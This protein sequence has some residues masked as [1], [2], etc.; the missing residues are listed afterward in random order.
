[1]RKILCLAF[2]LTAI[3]A[4]APAIATDEEWLADNPQS[5][6][7]C[8]W[9]PIKESL[10]KTESCSGVQKG[11][12]TEGPMTKYGRARGKYQ[13][14][15]ETQNN[16]LK[17]YPECSGGHDCR[18]AN[19][20]NQ[21]CWP[22]QECL[23]DRLLAE[24]LDRARKDP[25]CQALI[26]Q[27]VSG[28][29][30]KKDC[31]GRYTCT[32][33]VTWSG[34]AAAMHLGGSDACANV[35]ANGVGDND[36]HTSESGYM[37]EHSGVAVPQDC[38]PP[39]YDPGTA[40]PTLTLPQ[41]EFLENTGDTGFINTGGTIKQNWVAGLMLMAEQFSVNME[42]QLEAIGML[43]DAKDQQEAQRDFQRK[44]AEAHRD[45]QPSEQ[46]CTFGSF[47]TNLASTHRRAD[48]TR[49]ALSQE[50][51]QRETAAGD[52]KGKDLDSDSL[53]RL[54]QYRDTYCNKADNGNGLSMLCPKEIDPDM[55]NRDINYTT[56]IDQPLTLDINLT[57]TETTKDEQT[58]FALI[59]YL[60][61]HDP[62]PR[63][64][65]DTLKENVVELRKFQYH[66]QNMRSIVAMRGIARNSFSNIIALKSASPD[67]AERSGPYLKA[68]M[69]EMGLPDEEVEKLL[70]E[71]PSYYAQM[72]FLTKRIYQNPNFY[73]ALYDKPAN[74][75]RIRA[76]MSGIKLMNDRD[77]HAAML[78]REMLLSMML[79]LKLREKADTIYS[80]T[81]RALFRTEE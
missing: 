19:I 51:L 33:T 7:Q 30:P 20:Y 47:S 56:A 13:F 32:G 53:S 6:G 39:A 52:S 14:V 60:F 28:P 70:G 10:A 8:D 26:G 62:M 22:A 37:C 35:R 54:K 31:S 18:G 76:A 50:I 81:Q 2:M 75:K 64:N 43:W 58:I 42:A 17:R 48:L 55:Q 1:M 65:R 44:V 34:I 61:M 15:E 36:G 41:I 21:V 71:N 72:E 79:E 29:T 67:Q 57:D 25:D 74:V 49:T 66:Y 27:A 46:M 4:S 9:N 80:E 45:Y 63:I 3:F 11:Y 68:L 23:M 59:D 69:K 12:T 73:S 5:G 16:M 38:T 24:N 78:R 40:P 77:I